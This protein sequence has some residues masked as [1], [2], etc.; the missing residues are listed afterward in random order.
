MVIKGE[1]FVYLTV[2]N[3]HSMNAIL[4]YIRRNL[5]AFIWIIALLLLAFSGT[6]F[7]DSPTLCPFHNLGWDFCPG[8]GLGRSI[9]LLF[10][11]QIRESFDMHPAAIPAVLIL[12]WRIVT[13]LRRPASKVK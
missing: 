1:K 2:V 4:K 8:C 12:V 11:G 13:L 6:D 3:L 5:E 10:H 9:I 7:N